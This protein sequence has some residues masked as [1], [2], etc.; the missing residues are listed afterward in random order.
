LP[1]LPTTGLGDDTQ[2]DI[3]DAP[4]ALWHPSISASGEFARGVPRWT[5]N[6]VPRSREYLVL[7]L[8]TDHHRW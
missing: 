5:L 6:R 3:G 2:T 4:P 7:R 1:D 8:D